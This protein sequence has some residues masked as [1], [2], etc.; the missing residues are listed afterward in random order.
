MLKDYNDLLVNGYQINSLQ[1]VPLDIAALNIMLADSTDKRSEYKIAT[2]FCKTVRDNMVKSDIATM[3]SKRWDKDIAEVKDYIKVR[4]NN[5][6]ELLQKMHGFDDCW[7]DMKKF[8]SEEGTGLGFKSL[9]ESI[10]ASHQNVIANFSI[11]NFSLIP[12]RWNLADE[13]NCFLLLVS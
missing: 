9:D 1:T 10:F 2:D 8:M 11:Q 12:N 6:E 13:R 5:D 3:L 4:G 7:T